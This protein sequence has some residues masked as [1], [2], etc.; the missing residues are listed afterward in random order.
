VRQQLRAVVS[1]YAPEGEIV[2]WFHL[3]RDP[4]PGVGEDL[5]A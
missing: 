1:G 4:A 3:R 2:D 5:G